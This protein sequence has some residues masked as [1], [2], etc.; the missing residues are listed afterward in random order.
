M[1]CIL[2]IVLKMIAYDDA[3][4]FAPRPPMPEVHALAGIMMW[5]GIASA[6]HHAAPL[7]WRRVTIV[8]DWSAI[9]GFGAYL[10]LYCRPL[11]H[12]TFFVVWGHEARHATMAGHVLLC[13]LLFCLDYTT[14]DDNPL[15]CSCQRCPPMTF[16]TLWHL[17][18]AW[19]CFTLVLHLRF[20]ALVKLANSP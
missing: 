12:M 11:L 10:L 17:L 18:A 4:E 13:A 2:A 20:A 8:L 3:G 9:V 16:H 6:M 15:G 7:R 1:F 19:T 5:Q 14:R